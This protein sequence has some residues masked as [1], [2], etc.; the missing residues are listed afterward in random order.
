MFAASM[1]APSY[2]ASKLPFAIRHR[3]TLY[4]TKFALCWIP[5]SL[6][7]VVVVI[8]ALIAFAI[9]SVFRDRAQDL[10]R[11]WIKRLVMSASDPKRTSARRSTTC[12]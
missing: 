6:F 11:T 10:K 8:R 5:P 1:E 3:P 2:G 7:R 9:V 12:V 4:A